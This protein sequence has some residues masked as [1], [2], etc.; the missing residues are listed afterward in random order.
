MGAIDRAES[1]LAEGRLWKAR[2][3][4]QGAVSQSPPSQRVLEMLGDVLWQMGDA[5]RAGATWYLTDRDD[6]R[7]QEAFSAMNERYGGAIALVDA[8]PI[9]GPLD[10]YPPLAQQR[11][12]DLQEKSRRLG[13]NWEPRPEGASRVEV[14]TWKDKVGDF[15]S[16]A[17]G[18]GLLSL[19]IAGLYG[20]VALGWDVLF[21]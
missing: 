15:I 17:M 13:Y 2:D 1:A 21:G 16:I 5:P 14:R 7:A 11:L 9:K 6:E 18:L 4:L 20:L 19:V 10:A 8:I 12:I 3:H